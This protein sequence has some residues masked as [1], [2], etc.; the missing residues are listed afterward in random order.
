MNP[1]LTAETKETVVTLR[2]VS[3]NTTDVNNDDILEIPIQDYV[4]SVAQGESTEKLYLTNWCSF[5]GENLTVQKT[6]MI[7]VNDSYSFTIPSRWLG[8]IAILKNTTSRVRE[9]YRYN[10]EGEVEIVGE[11]LILI[12][13]MKKSQWEEEKANAP[14][15]EEILITEDTVFIAI[16]SD[17][18][19]AE[20]VT[21]D[22]VKSNFSI[23]E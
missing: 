15:S 8:K 10:V 12:K 20:G 23:F 18:A 4:P 19:R 2:S 11:S 1:L 6:T 22:T 13:A 9:I 17:A 21:I 14:K 5:N 16:I 3:Y 7:N